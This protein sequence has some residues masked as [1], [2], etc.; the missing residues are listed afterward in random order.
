MSYDRRKLLSVLHQ[1]GADVLREGGG[2]TILR[3]LVGKQASL[4]RHSQLN[5]ITVRKVVKQ[6][7]LDWQQVEKEIG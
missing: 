6:L 5:R 2:H 7:G 1:Q 3:S 4:P